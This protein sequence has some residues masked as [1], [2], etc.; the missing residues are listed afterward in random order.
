MRIGQRGLDLIKEFEGLELEAY[1]D[2][3]GIWTIGYGH[4]AKAGQPEVIPGME[5]T[6]QEAER[7][8]QSDLRP[9]EDA[10]ESAVKV[11]ISQ[12]MFDAL[13]SI[14]FNIGPTAMRNST[15]IRR[16]NA[17]DYPGAAD[18]MLMWNKAGGKVVAGLARRREAERALFLDGYNEDAGPEDDVR[19]LPVEEN[20]SRR[21][22]LG[23]S[24]TMGGAG[25]GAAAGTAAIA[26]TVAG[27]GDQ[28]EDTTA[29]EEPAETTETS[30]PAET[31]AETGEDSGEEPTED[32]ETT[33]EETSETEGEETNDVPVP[34]ETPET[35]ETIEQPSDDLFVS[36][37][38]GDEAYDAVVIGAGAIAIMAGLYVAIAR[39]DDWRNHRR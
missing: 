21:G 9:F 16:L 10:V 24:R 31:E 1:Q 12:N 6:E 8:L 19:G 37:F 30:D 36:R 39:L 28:A 26:A 34:D 15:F 11:E 7:I 2:I 20:S 18:A 29:D 38:D 35:E 33:P 17:R 13:V 32:G 22:N 27:G 3:V 4:T 5:I 14:T 25:A 23:E